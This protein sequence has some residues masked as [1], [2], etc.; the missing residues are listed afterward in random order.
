MSGSLQGDIGRLEAAASASTTGRIPIFQS[1]ELKTVTPDQIASGASAVDGPVSAT[2]NAVARFDGTTGKLIQ[3][4]AA[5]ISDTTGALSIAGTT[6]QF[7][8]GTTN[9]TTINATAPSSSRVITL[10]DPGANANFITSAGIGG[11][12][13]SRCTTQTDYTS[14]TTLG[15]VTGLTATVLA[16][17]VYAFE[18][19]IAG[20]ATA[21]GGMKLAIG[22]TAT[23]TSI[24]VTGQNS[25]ANTS[26]A[27]TTVT[28]LATA[29][30]GATA[31]FTD[32]TIRGTIVV[33]AAGTLTVQAAQNA[34]SVD[35][36]S[37]YV[38][39][40]FIV[41]RIA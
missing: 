7:V 23:A 25:N 3:N 26:N 24:S 12:Q 8:L 27:H 14:N 10:A 33:N 17:G 39:S 9:T 40:H 37:V 20:T 30:S 4:S 41:T 18:A 1:G 29:V 38:N 6:N 34:S 31:V 19:Y 32:G 15:N 22:G 5:T 36:S 2:D 28:A 13:A 16:A 11:V 35:T 21:N